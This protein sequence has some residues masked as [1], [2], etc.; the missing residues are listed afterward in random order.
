MNTMK[1]AAIPASLGTGALLAP[2][3]SGFKKEKV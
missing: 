3:V 2:G 1:S